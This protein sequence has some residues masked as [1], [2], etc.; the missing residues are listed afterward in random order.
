[1]WVLILIYIVNN[2]V[3]TQR[4]DGYTSEELCVEHATQLIQKQNSKSRRGFYL[5]FNC[6][7]LIKE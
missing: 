3:D 1:M 6:I 2:G 4:L 5:D 7:K